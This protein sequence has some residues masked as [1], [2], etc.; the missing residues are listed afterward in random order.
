ME[1]TKEK[2]EENCLLILGTGQADTDTRQEAVCGNIRNS[3]S[4]TQTHIHT[5]FNQL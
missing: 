5:L 2:A 4:H 3:V 1:T